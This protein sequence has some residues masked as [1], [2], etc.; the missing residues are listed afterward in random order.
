M[1]INNRYFGKCL[2]CKK[3]KELSKEHIPPRCAFNKNT[4][5]Y[6]NSFEVFEKGLLPWDFDKLNTEIMQ[7]GYGIYCFC[8]DCNTLLGN[9]Y[10]RAYKSFVLGLHG[11]IVQTKI[12]S[13]Q[14]LQIKKAPIKP[15]N[16]I[17]Q[18]ISNFYCINPEM[19]DNKDFDICEFLSDKNKKDFPKNIHFYIYLTK[20]QIYSPIQGQANIETGDLK[21][22]SEIAHYPLGIIMS[23]NTVLT[24]EYCIDYFLSYDYDEIVDDSFILKMKE[25]NMPLIQDYRTKKD[26]GIE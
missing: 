1:K 14:T 26:F 25:R 5:K 21:I 23:I 9:L 22:F 24:D 19:F 16:I 4:V 8:R 7:G 2:L 11:A 20:S 18:I 12:E 3:Q 17:K 6:Y 15:L 13:N 10:V